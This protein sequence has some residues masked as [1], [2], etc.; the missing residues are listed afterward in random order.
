MF[1][2]A[3]ELVRY[4]GSAESFQRDPPRPLR[5]FDPE[6]I[7][8]DPFNDPLDRLTVQQSHLHRVPRLRQ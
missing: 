8:I 4:V 2:Y 6:T 1:L 7:T 5:A 3:F